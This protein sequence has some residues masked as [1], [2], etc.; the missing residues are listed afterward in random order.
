M[1]VPSVVQRCVS[2]F[3][4]TTQDF[5]LIGHNFMLTEFGVSLL[6]AATITDDRSKESFRIECDK[7][8]KLTASFVPSWARA[9]FDHLQIANIRLLDQSQYEILAN[10]DENSPMVTPIWTTRG[11]ESEDDFVSALIDLHGHFQVRVA[12]DED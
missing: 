7:G 4:F 2:S 10:M 6:I 9:M 8:G 11:I 3:E 12:F 1:G 5:W